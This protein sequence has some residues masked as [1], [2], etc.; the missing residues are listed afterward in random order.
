MRLPPG[1]YFFCIRQSMSISPY[2]LVLYPLNSF[3]WHHQHRMGC[4]EKDREREK[5]RMRPKKRDNCMDCRTQK[6]V[7]SGTIRLACNVFIGECL[8]NILCCG[9]CHSAPLYASL[10]SFVVWT[11]REVARSTP[12][13]HTGR[14]TYLCSVQLC[15]KNNSWAVHLI[16]N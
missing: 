7:K 9:V 8:S 3:Y 16:S 11:D 12:F 15:F 4:L 13:P 5:E 10:N 2:D 1:F 6:L 14:M